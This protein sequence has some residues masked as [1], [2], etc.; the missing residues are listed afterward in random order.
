MDLQSRLYQKIDAI[1]KEND[2]FLI[3]LKV[4]GGRNNMVIQVFADTEDGITLGQCEKI[5]R[6]I[7]D[8]LDMDESFTRYYRLDVSSP[9]LDR[10]L[11]H[12][13]QF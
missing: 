10:P 2:C 1:C 13:F 11:V 12:D 8:D 7:Q 3:D 4:K 9:G 5:N 6:L